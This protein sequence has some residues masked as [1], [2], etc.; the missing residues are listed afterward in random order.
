MLTIFPNYTSLSFSALPSVCRQELYL[1]REVNAKQ[2]F[3]RPFLQIIGLF[4]AI[5]LFSYLLEFLDLFLGKHA[6][7]QNLFKFQFNFLGLCCIFPQPIL[8]LT[9]KK[10]QSIHNLVSTPMPSVLKSMIFPFIHQA[11]APNLSH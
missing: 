5:F 4:V 2:V 8:I 3:T 9:R 11:L 10:N 7:P 6:S 1:A